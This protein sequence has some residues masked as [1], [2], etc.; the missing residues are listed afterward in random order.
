M[1]A[2]ERRLNRLETAVAESARHA[3]AVD[4]HD[5]AEDFREV[6][7]LPVPADT[8]PAK[9]TEGVATL[10]R[11]LASGDFADFV[12]WRSSCSDNYQP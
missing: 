3:P 6:F 12:K 8:E 5:P 4:T 2:L 11:C 7:G 10:R 1:I 9:I